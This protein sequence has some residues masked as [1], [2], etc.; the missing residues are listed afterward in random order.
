MG[1]CILCGK[2]AGLF[3]SLHKACFEKYTASDKVICKHLYEGLGKVEPSVL[4][5]KVQEQVASYGFKAEAHQRTLN[6]ALEFFPK[7]YIE[8]QED[9]TFSISSW[10]EVL[11]IL[12]PEEALCVNPNFISQQENLLA[13]RLLQQNMLPE[14]NCN[15]TNFSISLREGEELWWCFNNSYV[16]QLTPT[17]NKRQWSVVM[18]IVEGML[19]RKPKRALERK[20][21]GEGKILLTNQ[22]LCFESDDQVAEMEYRTIYSCTPVGDGI[23]LQSNELKAIPQTYVCGDGRL[24]YSFVRYAQKSMGQ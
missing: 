24:L 22:R 13:I 11:R 10:I 16:E 21:L 9:L 15:P 4:A 20:N 1:A 18:Q 19:P 12:S 14:S 3:Y 5:Q 6:R 8:K 23:C 2:S 17:I 7:R